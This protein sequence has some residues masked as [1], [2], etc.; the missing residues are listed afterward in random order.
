VQ[1]E[2]T[3]HVSGRDQTGPGCCPLAVAG[4]TTSPL[5][6]GETELQLLA[7]LVAILFLFSPCGNVGIISEHSTRVRRVS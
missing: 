6:S 1:D 2:T 3:I 4:A 5:A 7:Y